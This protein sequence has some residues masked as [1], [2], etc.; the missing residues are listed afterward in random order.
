MVIIE[1]IDIKR[2]KKKRGKETTVPF[3]QRNL[4]MNMY[5]YLRILTPFMKSRDGSHENS[6]ISLQGHDCSRNRG[7]ENL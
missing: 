2:Q 3:L 1:I 6:V 4:N 5:G 7:A